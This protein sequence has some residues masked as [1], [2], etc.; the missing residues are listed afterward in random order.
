MSHPSHTFFFFFCLF[1]YTLKHEK[2]MEYHYRFSED[3]HINAQE[4]KSCQGFK[5]LESCVTSPE[6]VFNWIKTGGKNYVG[7]ISA[8]LFVQNKIRELCL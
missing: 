5:N 4:G 1:A 3:I 8:F 2:G 6:N 7:V